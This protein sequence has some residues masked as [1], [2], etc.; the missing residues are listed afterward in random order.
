VE[1]VHEGQKELGLGDM[2]DMLSYE[3]LDFLAVRPFQWA[4]TPN[5]E[6]LEYMR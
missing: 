3:R 1:C 2:R 6:W 5:I 4:K